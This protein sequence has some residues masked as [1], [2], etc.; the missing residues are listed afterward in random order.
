MTTPKNE[1][2]APEW[3]LEALHA[4]S[5]AEREAAHPVKAPPGLLGCLGD[6][7]SLSYDCNRPLMSM[8]EMLE[9]CEEVGE[10][11]ESDILLTLIGISRAVG[12]V[13]GKRLSR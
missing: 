8:A 3:L 5:W 1:Q 11:S 9:Y 12:I 7:V 6:I 4:A 10:V 13:E 2:I